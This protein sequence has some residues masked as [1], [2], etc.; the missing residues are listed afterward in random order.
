M[1][2]GVYVDG[3]NL[4]YGARKHCGR[5]TPGWRWLDLRKLVAPLAKWSDSEISRI[6]YCTA[7]VDA[8]DNATGSVDQAIYL[9]ALSEAGSVDVIAEGRYVSWAKREPLVNEVVGTFRPSVYVHSDE[10]WDA[11]LPLRT[12]P[13]S[14]EQASSAVMATV[15]KREEKGSD[16]NVASHLLFDV[17]VGVVDAAIVVTNDSDLELPLRMARSHVPVGTV[18]PSTNPTAGALKGRHDDGVGR[19]WWRRLTAEDYRAAQFP[20][21]IGHLRKPVGW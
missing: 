16:V 3:F 2:V 1:R 17:L 21:A 4:Y 7:R 10:T 18:N 13:M 6:V 20:D 11:R 14:P 8:A 15:R 9:E 12:T 5:G 19:H